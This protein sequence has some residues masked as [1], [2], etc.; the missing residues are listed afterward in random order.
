MMPEVTPKDIPTGASGF[1]GSRD[2]RPLAS[3]CG[4]DHSG[5]MLDD[6][7]AANGRRQD[8]SQLISGIMFMVAAVVFL[9]T[10]LLGDAG[11]DTAFFVLAMVFVVLALNAWQSSR[12]Q[13]DT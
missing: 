5:F 7:A 4:G 2:V 13:S 1:S 6:E 10:A 8:R 9:L 12:S 11:A 3:R